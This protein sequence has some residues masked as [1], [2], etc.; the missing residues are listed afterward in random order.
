MISSP[1]TVARLVT[2]RLAAIFDVRR[3]SDPTARVL[4]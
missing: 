1:W 2:P 3:A 4:S